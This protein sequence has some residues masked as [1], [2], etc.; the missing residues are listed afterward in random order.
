MN[1]ALYPLFLPLVYTKSV[2]FLSG[3]PKL[4]KMDTSKN[5]V[6]GDD[7]EI[8]CNVSGYP[9]PTV[10]WFKDGKRLMS[11]KRIT[12]SDNGVYR[13]AIL[14]I[15]NLEFE[16]KGEYTCTATSPENP[17]GVSA[18]IDISV[19]GKSLKGKF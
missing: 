10:N 7:L 17:L 13:K 4:G 15:N 5:V 11:D 2:I 14:G 16:D 19:K 18:T 9:Y 12:L 1:W 6:L 8:T 3:A